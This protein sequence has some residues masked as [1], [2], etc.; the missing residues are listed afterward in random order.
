M[1][2]SGSK[3]YGEFTS[4]DVAFTIAAHG[5]I[6]RPASQYSA[7]FRQIESVDTPDAYTVVM[8]LS[9]PNP[10]FYAFCCMPRFGGYM[11]SRKAVEELG[12]KLRLNPVGSG[13]FEFVSYEPKQKIVCAAFDQYWDGKPKIDRLEELFLTGNRAAHAGL[14]Q[15]RRRHDRGRRGAR[16]VPEPEEAEA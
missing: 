6:R 9:Q 15:G 1:A 10:F 2:C 14:R 7:N 8:H 13:P 3:G 12:D 11:Q 16:L 5:A 4:D